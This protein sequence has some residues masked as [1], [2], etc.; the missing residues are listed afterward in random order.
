MFDENNL[1]KPIDWE[2]INTL[3]NRVRDALELYMRGDVSIGR[4]VEIARLSYREF[5]R[6]QAKARVPIHH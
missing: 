3:S 2:F 5:D 4:A 6:I 1:I